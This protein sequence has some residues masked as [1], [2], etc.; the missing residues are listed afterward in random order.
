MLVQDAY[1]NLGAVPNSPVHKALSDLSAK[2]WGL[3]EIM[4]K[5]IF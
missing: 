2:V 3:K 5:E 4:D 1:L